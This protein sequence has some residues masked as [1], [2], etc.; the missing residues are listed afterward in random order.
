MTEVD[1]LA[2]GALTRVEPWPPAS[3][4]PKIQRVEVRRGGEVDVPSPRHDV[5]YVDMPAERGR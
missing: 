4:G 1:P 2:G 3:L 5:A